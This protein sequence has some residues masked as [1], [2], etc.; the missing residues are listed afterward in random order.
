MKRRW[1][2]QVV[3]PSVKILQT[4]AS[5]NAMCTMVGGDGD[6]SEG[7]SQMIGAMCEIPEWECRPPFAEEETVAVGVAVGI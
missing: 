6:F 5:D 4:R 2:F 1:E 7:L 3:S